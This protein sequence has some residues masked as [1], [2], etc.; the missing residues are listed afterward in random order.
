MDEELFYCGVC[1]KKYRRDS[2]QEVDGEERD[3]AYQDNLHIIK[4]TIQAIL[5]QCPHR[6]TIGARHRD[7][8]S[9]FP[10]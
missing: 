7:V 4:E 9:S 5:I 10:F 2:T 8:D 3:I 6:H 1:K